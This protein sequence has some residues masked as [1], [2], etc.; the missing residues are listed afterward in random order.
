MIHTLYC[1]TILHLRLP[2]Y[3][4]FFINEGLLLCDFTVA[5]GNNIHSRS[6]AKFGVTLFYKIIISFIKYKFCLHGIWFC[7]VHRQKYD[8]ELCKRGEWKKSSNWIRNKLQIQKPT[9]FLLVLILWSKKGKNLPNLI[10]VPFINGD[11][12]IINSY[13]TK[14]DSH[15]CNKRRGMLIV[16]RRILEDFMEKISVSSVTQLYPTLCDPM[17][18]KYAQLPCP[19]PT[20]KACSDSCPLSQWC[21]PTISSSVIPFSSC[22]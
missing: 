6:L 15:Y 21:P 13:N 2:H 9:V 12:F 7:K 11:R 3:N 22:L 14:K 19:S 8:W 16:P 18:C 10:T 1:N 4:N 17:D 5:L 20:P